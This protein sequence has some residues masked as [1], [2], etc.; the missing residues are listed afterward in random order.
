MRAQAYSCQWRGKRTEGRALPCACVMCPNNHDQSIKHWPHQ[1][2][3]HKLPNEWSTPKL[4]KP[5]PKAR[6]DATTKQQTAWQSPHYSPKERSFHFSP[7]LRNT[8]PKANTQH[9]KPQSKK[10]KA[11][12]QNQN[13]KTPKPQSPKAPEIL[14]K[15]FLPFEVHSKPIA[16]VRERKRS[17]ALSSRC[18]R[19]WPK[20]F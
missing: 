18:L 16:A 7:H 19:E 6:I 13:P 8:K 15:D 11:K 4:S 5:K 12:S 10:P 2:H 1:K 17:P 9:P 20:A 14:R 3:N